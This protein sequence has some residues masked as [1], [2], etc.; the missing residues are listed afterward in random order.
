M[1]GTRAALSKGGAAVT[2]EPLVKGLNGGGSLSEAWWA[3]VGAT[4]GAAGA[5]ALVEAGRP[6]DAPVP[7]P[8][9]APPPF[10]APPGDDGDPLAL[11]VVGAVVGTGVAAPVADAVGVGETVPPPPGD[12]PL[13]GLDVGVGELFGFF[14]AACEP[15]VA[16]ATCRLFAAPS[17]ITPAIVARASPTAAL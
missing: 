2:A 9:V 6:L 16:A 15:A 13:A 11:D 17:A 1:G 5:A 10:E 8:P 4:R 3:W 14:A 7:L 12:V